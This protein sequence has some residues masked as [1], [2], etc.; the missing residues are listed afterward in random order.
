MDFVKYIQIAEEAFALYKELKDSGVLDQVKA[1]AHKDL[2]VFHSAQPPADAANDQHLQEVVMA[3]PK[4][5]DLLAK[6]EALII[7]KK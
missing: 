6:V 7:G 3:H 4:A 2:A 5:A 1:A